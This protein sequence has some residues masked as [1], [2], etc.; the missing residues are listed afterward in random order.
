[1]TV[2]IQLLPEETTFEAESGETIL[3]AA[4][5]QG[6]GLPYGCRNGQ[7]G[8]CAGHLV[9][10]WI[11]YPSGLITA[12]EG[13]KAGT[14]LT[15]QA[16]PTSDLV[17]EIVQR[18]AP[19]EIEVR[20]LP[21]RLERKEQLNHDVVRLMLKLPEQQRLQFLAG[22]YVEL[23]L[24][25]GRTR[26]F[27]IANA[28]QDDAFL[29]LHIRQIAGG[30]VTQHIF[31][32]LQERSI[33]RIRGPLGDFYLREDSQRPI[34]MVGGGTGFAPLKAMIEQAVAIGLQRPI[35]LYWGVRSRRDLYLPELP[36]QW[37][38]QLPNFAFTPV[39][40]EPDA[41][42]TGRTGW[43][44]EAVLQD[45]PQ[46]GGHEVYTAGP[47]AMIEA[48]EAAFL[49]QGLDRE[50]LL[51]DAFTFSSKPAVDANGGG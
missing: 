30:E 21:C 35:H 18:R 24:K 2:K 3:E 31:D 37:S 47:P 22:Q 13:K 6:V 20:T 15:C 7:C 8:S 5:R 10:G 11:Q 50:H 25:D 32:A 46:L 4:L 42:W 33:L 40:S 27:S 17:L 49:A 12:L 9:S 19:A 43:V 23:S 36:S 14:C 26:A 29:E 16:V 28:P 39:L 38:E 51:S 44:H 48:A 45:K 1:M 41:D 34:I